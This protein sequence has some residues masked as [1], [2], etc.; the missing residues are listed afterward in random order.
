MSVR[1][2]YTLTVVVGR[3]G[4]EE[5]A[6][7][8]GDVVTVGST[9]DAGLRLDDKGVKDMHARISC[10]EDALQLML[11]D[12]HTAKVN[13]LKAKGEKRLRNGD[14]IVFGDAVVRV[15]KRKH[16]Y[17][18]TPRAGEPSKPPEPAAEDATSADAAPAADE[19]PP[20]EP[21]ELAEEASTEAPTQEPSW[22]PPP[23]TPSSPP[24]PAR[25]E[26][27]HAEQSLDVAPSALDEEER[28][29]ALAAA[30]RAGMWWSWEQ[31]PPLALQH[32]W[33]DIERDTSWRSLAIVPVSEG[34]PVL[35]VAHA[36]ARM[37][38]MNPRSN[39]LVVDATPGEPGEDQERNAATVAAAVMRNPGAAY[40]FLDATALGM[41][42][43]DVAHIYVPQLLQYISTE[44]ANHKKV[45]IALGPLIQNAQSIPVARRVDSVLLGIEV[46][47]T[48]LPDVS[49]TADIIGR[50]RVNGTLALER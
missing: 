22:A 1:T 26:P 5:R 42:D 17:S 16:F 34:L 30:K 14:R 44:E 25:D 48:R 21:L 23:P 38:S 9:A 36:F 45:I 15:G 24:A 33:F 20:A 47:Q 49:R 11:L 8:D 3:Q 10:E 50:E 40:D 46:G 27:E 32:V 2:Y 7:A 4:G 39:V 18:E 6:L 12:G 13:G 41:N 43:A 31:M 28:S 19:A 35:A 29:A 37:A